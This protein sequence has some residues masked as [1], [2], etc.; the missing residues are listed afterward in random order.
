MFYWSF[1]LLYLWFPRTLRKRANLPLLLSM[2]Y[3]LYVSNIRLIA[4]FRVWGVN[5][6]R[7]RFS[8][9]MCS[10]KDD[11]LGW[12]MQWLRWEGWVGGGNDAGCRFSI[13]M[14]FYER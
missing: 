11:V 14:M 13:Q 7:R 1:T 2:E 8:T 5:D 3:R 4:R 6:V 9:K 10:S 12:V